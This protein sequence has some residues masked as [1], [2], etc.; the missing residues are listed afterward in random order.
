MEQTHP[1]HEY[2]QKRLTDFNSISTHRDLHLVASD[3]MTVRPVVNCSCSMSL[4][5]ADFLPTDVIHSE[6]VQYQQLHNNIWG[7]IRTQ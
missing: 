2:I 6:C 1:G 7:E 3:N 5:P 4:T